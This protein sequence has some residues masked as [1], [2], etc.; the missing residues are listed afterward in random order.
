LVLP[1]LPTRERF[2]CFGISGAVPAGCL[3]GDNHA[4]NVNGAKT[5]FA[6]EHEHAGL[7]DLR[8]GVSNHDSN[9]NLQAGQTF[10]IV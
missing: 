7:G 10:C 8:Q 1:G 9:F 6:H 2:V 4:A 5:L 3:L